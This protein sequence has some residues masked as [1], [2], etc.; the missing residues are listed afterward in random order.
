[1]TEL[2]S[3]L[4]EK[5]KSIIES[6]ISL[7]YSISNLLG[8]YCEIVIHSI[9]NLDH[10]VVH[11]ING[12]H[13]GRVVGSSITDK[14]LQLLKSYQKNKDITKHSY[15]SRLP[16]GQLL[17]SVT[18]III[19]HQGEP[20]GLFCI[21]LNLSYPFDKVMSNMFSFHE[22]S[23]YKNENFTS[24]S[25]EL[26]ESVFQNAVEEVE[27]N[28][29]SKSKSYNKQIIFNLFENGIFELKDAV[30]YVS[31][32]LGLTKHALYKHIRQFKK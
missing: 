10:S 16:S 28:I 29:S 30:S 31:E 11:I 18:H 2:L 8:E 21:N 14:G 25:Q 26:L 23:L 15:F 5:D 13:T 22:N 32:K 20:I 9:N 17:K 7:S 6:Y 1:M 4:D 3:A 12:H 24:N 27:Q 19:G